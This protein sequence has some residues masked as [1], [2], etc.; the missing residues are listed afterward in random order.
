MVVAAASSDAGVSFCTSGTLP[1]AGIGFEEC[2]GMRKGALRRAISL[3]D[4]E[5]EG[6]ACRRPKVYVGSGVKDMRVGWGGGRACEEMVSA[7][8]KSSNRRR[9]SSCTAAAVL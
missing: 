4:N 5:E 3:C 8:L 7:S 9:K 2:V 6:E 1:S